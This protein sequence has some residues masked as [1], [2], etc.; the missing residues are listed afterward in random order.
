MIPLSRVLLAHWIARDDEPRV[1]ATPFENAALSD[2]PREGEP[3]IRSD[4][5]TATTLNPERSPCI[6]S[7]ARQRAARQTSSLNRTSTV[8]TSSLPIHI[9]RISTTL[10]SGCNP[11]KLPIGPIAPN[12][13]PMLPR[14]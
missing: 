4:G 14:Q 1:G 8:S 2:L 11:A 5:R 3:A 9:R 7:H 10:L 12:P 6:E 13:G